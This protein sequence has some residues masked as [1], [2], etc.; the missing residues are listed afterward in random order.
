VPENRAVVFPMVKHPFVLGFLV[1]EL[2]MEMCGNEESEGHDLIHCS[3]SPEEAYASPLS[4][5]MKSWEIQSVK[6]EPKRMYRFSAEQRA[7]AIN[8]ARSLAMAYVMDQVDNLYLSLALYF[9]NRVVVLCDNV[10]LLVRV[11]FNER[12]QRLNVYSVV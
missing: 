10:A 9:G 12:G 2:A 8:I 6:E 5:G 1:A 7:N 4:S 11:P 3:P